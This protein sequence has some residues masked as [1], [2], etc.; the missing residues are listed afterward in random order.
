MFKKTT[1]M[2][3]L[4]IYSTVSADQAI[5]LFSNENIAYVTEK[6]KNV[7]S[8]AKN[9]AQKVGKQALIKAIIIKDYLAKTEAA[10]YLKANMVIA[11][12]WIKAN[13]YAAA[14]IA[15][16][17]SATIV[18]GIVIKQNQRSKRRARQIYRYYYND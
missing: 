6:A 4:L 7:A 11:D 15:A 12:Q 5:S 9:I 3:A 14:G 16:L 13:P 2:L 10:A 8:V 17:S 18:T 1:L